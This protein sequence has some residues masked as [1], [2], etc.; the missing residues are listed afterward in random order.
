MYTHTGNRELRVTF[1]GVNTLTKRQSSDAEEEFVGTV[2]FFNVPT[3]IGW[4]C[5][6][7]L[8]LT[9]LFQ[10]R[11]RATKLDIVEE[12]TYIGS[13]LD[14]WQPGWISRSPPTQVVEGCGGKPHPQILAYAS[15]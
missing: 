14:A 2:P 11:E 8:V 13:I 10:I 6:R 7:E 9:G 4:N 15:C 12:G 5:W 1:D 3:Q